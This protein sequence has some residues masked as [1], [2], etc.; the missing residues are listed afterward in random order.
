M[1]TPQIQSISTL[2]KR[3]TAVSGD[4][5][6]WIKFFLTNRTQKVVVNGESLN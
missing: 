2:E 4:I 3:S 1:A 6:R 5:L